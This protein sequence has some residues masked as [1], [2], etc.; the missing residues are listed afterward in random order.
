MRRVRATA[1]GGCSC[2]YASKCATHYPSALLVRPCCFPRLTDC[3][4]LRRPGPQVLVSSVAS[5]Q[6]TSRADGGTRPHARLRARFRLGPDSAW[7]S[8]RGVRAGRS[9][10][11]G[12]M[13]CYST[14]RERLR[15]RLV[16]SI[17]RA[18]GAQPRSCTR[19]A[20]R[21]AHPCRVGQAEG[22]G[23]CIVRRAVG[24]CTAVM[25]WGEHL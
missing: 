25:D 3:L 7:M 23:Q 16:Q 13:L 9:V 5:E 10:H 21:C 8:A 15:R 18:L 19:C 24:I 1:T 2:L 11:C 6:V 12:G 4:R 22:R 14:V 20:V 17:G